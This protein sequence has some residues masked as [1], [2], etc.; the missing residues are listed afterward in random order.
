[1]NKAYHAWSVEGPVQPFRTLYG[2]ICALQAV[3]GRHSWMNCVMSSRILGRQQVLLDLAGSWQDERNEAEIV[4]VIKKGRRT[5]R[6]LAEICGMLKADL[7]KKGTPLDDF[8]LT[9]AA[10]AM[11]HNLIL[12]TNN[13]KHFKMIDGLKLANWAEPAE[14]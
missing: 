11:A 13:L 2:Y 8:D 1:M 5:S 12:V 3:Y 6:K 14:R 9:L 7:E 4:D 10:S